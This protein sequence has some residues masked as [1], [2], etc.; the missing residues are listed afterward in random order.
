MKKSLI[1]VAILTSLGLSGCFSSSSSSDSILPTTA[2]IDG[3]AVDGYLSG[4]FCYA[5]TDANGD[6]DSTVDVAA[7]ALTSS[8]GLFEITGPTDVGDYPIVCRAEAGAT[9]TATG[10]TFYGQMSAAAGSDFVTPMTT[11]VEELGADGVKAVFG[12]LLDGVTDLSGD[13]TQNIDLAQATVTVTAI[14]SAISQMLYLQTGNDVN[15]IDVAISN[16]IT[17]TVF[18]ALATELAAKE[19]AN[20]GSVDLTDVASAMGTVIQN[21]VDT[22]TQT[23]TGDDTATN[24][25]K[26]DLVADLENTIATIVT[27]YDA[28]TTLDELATAQSDA[29]DALDLNLDLSTVDATY[30]LV[31]TAGI[32]DDTAI[33]DDTVISGATST[34]TDVSSVSGGTI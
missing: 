2:T 25:D 14:V 9:D 8:T 30:T 1:S 3:Q 24:P 10:S 12:T 34:T 13:P 6:F 19:A 16:G 27:T 7:A 26:S 17:K 20:P 11:L 29:E 32:V 33:P 15:N 5:D 21:T 22:A 23:L 28:V 31:I 4:M 18:S